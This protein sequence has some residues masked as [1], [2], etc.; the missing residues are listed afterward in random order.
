MWKRNC[1]IMKDKLGR[2]VKI[3]DKVA[4]ASLKFDGNLQTYSCLKIG[5]VTHKSFNSITVCFDESGYKDDI[6][7]D[8]FIII[9]SLGTPISINNVEY[10]IRRDIGAFA[11][12]FGIT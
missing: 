12:S 4:V 10:E 2:K 1:L 6:T 5:T 8:E 11:H 7:N 9:S 3:N